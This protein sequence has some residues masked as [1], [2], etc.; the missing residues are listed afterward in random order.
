MR[1]HGPLGDEQP[2]RDLLVA[3]TLGNQLGDLNFPPGKGSGF[4][5]MRRGNRVIVG[6]TKREPHCR[7]AAQPFACVK[8]SSELRL[9][10]SSGRR[11]S[12]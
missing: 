7:L 4:A 6:F 10:Q 12:D 1:R 2:G 5:A 3:E 9:S 8:F 11:L